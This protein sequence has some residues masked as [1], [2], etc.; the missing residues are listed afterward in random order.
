MK[1][2]HRH[3][4][5]TWSVYNEPLRLDFNSFLWTRSDGNLLVD[6]LPITASDLKHLEELGGAAFIIITNSDHVRGAGELAAS[7]GAKV[8]GPRGEREKFPLPSVDF[9]KDGDEPLPGLKVREL[10]GS[11]T[12]GELALVLEET[13]AL[14]GD[15]VR[16]GRAD[17]LA[18]LPA[19]KLKDRARALD[20]LRRMRSL[21]PHIANVLVGDGYCAFRHGG[22]LLA[23]L[24]NS[25]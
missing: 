13:T 21:H 10:A 20:S 5:F 23:E 7:T 19:P 9:V 4:L 22:D 24:A 2:L 3:D 17:A 6:P 12:E 14:F 8:F 1:Q 15:L 16:S 25:S 18:L 11:K